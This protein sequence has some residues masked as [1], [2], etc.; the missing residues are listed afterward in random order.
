MHGQRLAQYEI[1]E[2]LGEGGMGTV[3][4]ARDTKLRRDV[5]LK[6]LERADG[7][8]ARSRILAEARAASHLNHPTIATIY[9]VGE[10]ESGSFIAM[11]L[12]VGPTLS[13]RVE[14]GPSDPSTVLSV[15]LQAARGLQVA[16]EN[17]IVHGDIKP[18]NLI[19][20]EDGLLKIL[21]FGVARPA[22]APRAGGPTV[23]TM[24]M[25]GLS[26]E[27]GG[28]AGTP[29]YMAPEQMRGEAVDARADLYALGVVLYE[30]GSGRRLFAAPSTAA[31]IADVLS[32]ERVD[33][34]E[35]ERHQSAA[36]VRIVRRLLERRAADRYPSAA[37]LEEDLAGLARQLERGDPPVAAHEA[38]AVAVLPFEIL[39]G[40]P[41]DEFLRLAL[42]QAVAHGLSEHSTLLVRPTSAVKRYAERDVD[43]LDAARE[44]DVAVLV[45][46]TIQRLG[47]QLRVQVQAWD[48]ASRT[49]TLSTRIDG[50]MSDLFGLQDRLTNV[51]GRGIGV[52]SATESPADPPTHNARAYELFLRASE[53][54]L[55][56]THADTQTAIEMLR[57]AVRL[58]PTFAS[59]WARL[60]GAL[61]AMDALFERDVRYA[62]EAARSID[63]ALS[64]DHGNAEAWC[65][66]GRMLWTQHHHFQ[67][68]EALRDLNKACHCGSATGDAE[69][70][71]GIILA[72]VGLHAESIA[73]MREGLRVEPGS[74]MHG[75]LLGEALV[76]DGQVAEGTEVMRDVVVRDPLFLYGNLFLP[77]GHLYGDD[78]PE[79]ERTIRNAREVIGEDGVLYAL[80]ALLWARRGEADRARSMVAEAARLQRSI[81]H[82]HHAHHYA[83]AALATLGDAPAAAAELRQAI[84]LGMPNHAAF[85]R[86]PHFAPVQSH[87]EFARVM[88]DLQPA[89]QALH[90]EFAAT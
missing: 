16:H 32:P 58:D 18:E 57:S 56:Y 2:H 12:I 43:P 9:E 78:L 37:G 46:G 26:L 42:A 85:L 68:A 88:S 39:A 61:V 25:R 84:E 75:L 89:W 27:P 49:T 70:W 90:D 64:L 15:G 82:E 59:G 81:S 63:R 41:E 19:L 62:E 36:L 38:R 20:K 67:H 76:F 54:L 4:R 48:A 45:E 34:G 5:A 21:D 72:H 73:I 14:A 65:A 11:E 51:V 35:L 66:R 6:L 71:R 69:L 47:P 8:I 22:S 50:D 53:R 87:P 86:D 60:A 17:G 28:V 10:A 3:Y 77:A 52:D 1:T 74:L 24:T 80:E 79:A 31:L 44:L 29:A 55:A 83:A 13:A 23:E 40:G 33:L 7:D 30:L